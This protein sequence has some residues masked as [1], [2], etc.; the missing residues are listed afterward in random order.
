MFLISAAMH[1]VALKGWRNYAEQG[2]AVAF[3]DTLR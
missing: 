1:N 2:D 3:H